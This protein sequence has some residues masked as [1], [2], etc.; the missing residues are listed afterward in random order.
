MTGLNW[1]IWRKH[2]VLTTA[3]DVLRAHNN[4][5]LRWLYDDE[6]YVTGPVGILQT[7]WCCFRSMW[8]FSCWL[9]E[10]QSHQ[11]F[12]CRPTVMNFSWTWLTA[13]QAP[14]MTC[15]VL[16]HRDVMNTSSTEMVWSSANRSWVTPSFLSM[17][18]R[19]WCTMLAVSLQ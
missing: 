4:R 15:F 16:F 12:L 10:S 14:D 8:C 7:C 6:I 9:E 17:E 18:V 11:C 3:V 1:N 2:K 13:C 19:T 5:P